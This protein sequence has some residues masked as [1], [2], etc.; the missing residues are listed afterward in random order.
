MYHLKPIR[1]A[2]A[3][4]VIPLTVVGSDAPAQSK[5]RGPVSPAEQKG[6]AE[7]KPSV[8]AERLQQLL[9]SGKVGAQPR[10]QRRGGGLIP[11]QPFP[12]PRPWELA[13]IGSPGL[14]SDWHSRFTFK[15]RHAQ[16]E[17]LAKRALTVDEMTF[18]AD[19]P[20]TVSSLASLAWIEFDQGKYLEAE[21]LYRRT[22][23]IREKALGPNHPDVAQSLNN[24]AAIFIKQRKYA[25]A[26]Q[27][28]KR[29]LAIVEK[30]L[31]PEHPGIAA[32][33]TTLAEVE[34]GPGPS[35]RG[36]DPIQSLVVPDREKSGAREPGRRRRPHEIRR[37]PPQDRP[38]RAGGG[39]R[40]SR[41]SDHGKDA[42]E[43]R[44][45][46]HLSLGRGADRQR[47]PRSTTEVIWLVHFN[48]SYQF[49]ARRAPESII[50]H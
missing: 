38:L 41:P 14:S 7:E 31:G 3:W 44:R 42:T 26:E 11:E 50:N 28:A 22:L 18:G 34:T 47:I 45:T 1:S 33:L 24:L 2:A 30:A 49:L 48:T 23:T 32:N 46:A 10:T 5:V 21:R 29:S 35:S 17:Q 6:A 20:H 19:H 16:A 40:G 9:T 13:M 43:G 25:E 12:R 15:G 36:R 37:L 8:S 39:T 27:F 4:L